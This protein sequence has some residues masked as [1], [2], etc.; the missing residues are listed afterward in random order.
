MGLIGFYGEPITIVTA[1]L[2]VVLV[3]VG[4]SA[5]L[6]VYYNLIRERS[7]EANFQK[8]VFH[9]LE[10]IISPLIVAGVTTFVGGI[11]L[12]VFKIKP[13]QNFGLFSGVGSLVCL[14]VSLL[15]IPVLLRL[16][17]TGSRG[18]AKNVLD[19]MEKP[20]KQAF[21]LGGLVKLARFSAEQPFFVLASLLL[22]LGYSAHYSYKMDIGYDNLSFLPK[23]DPVRSA[24]VRLR[25][26]MNGLRSF[27][28]TLDTKYS[29][30][31]LDLKFLE[32]VHSFQDRVK[33]VPDVSRTFS[34]VDLVVKVQE[35]LNPETQDLLPQD[36]DTVAQY[37]FLIGMGS[38]T[39]SYLS[40]DQRKLRVAVTMMTNDTRATEAAY[41]KVKAMAEEHFGEGVIVRA[42]GFPIMMVALMRYLVWGKIQNMLMA[43]LL[44]FLIVTLRYRSVV[45]GIITTLPL[46]IGVITNFG[47]MGYMGIRLDFVTAIITSFAMGIGIDFSI[48]FVAALRK[49]YKETGDLT[50]AV[51][52]AVS[53]P[54]TAI[55]YNAVICVA[56]F[57]VLG[58]SKFAPVNIFAVLMCFN[59]V[60]L[61]LAT[62]LVLPA[63]IQIFRPQFITGELGYQTELGRKFLMA[64]KVAMS[65]ALVAVLTV[66]IY[67]AEA[68]SAET[69]A[70]LLKKSI[71]ASHAK[72][73]ESVYIM[74]LIS[75]DGQESAPRKMNVW[76]QSEGENAK[77]MIKFVEPANIRGTGFL[78]VIEKDD[79]SQWLYLP[80][81]KKARRVSGGN[82]DEPFLGSDFTMGDISVDKK[83]GFEFKLSGEKACD[84]GQCYVLEGTPKDSDSL[85][86]KQ[87]RLIHKSHYLNV[88]SEFY[89]AAG[90][91]EKVM[92]L[93]NI[94][95][96]PDGRMAPGQVEMKN[97]LTG[98]RTVIEYAKRNT[99]KKPSA[100]VFTKR[101]L[102]K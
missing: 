37:L 85:Y 75:K 53:G 51:E 69:P 13:L 11:T 56:G 10:K 16:V 64:S 5:A 101:Y 60:V 82:S 2:P 47:L 102:E 63:V 76:F 39:A 44:I 54:G 61:M 95:K 7:H 79:A 66:G 17:G 45:R 52:H 74:K 86:S 99:S 70:S 27:D 62:F 88:R 42:G 50:A 20:E 25:E 59:M 33:E 12:L 96:G 72:H 24:A 67:V 98:S 18:A 41:E 71:K 4:C 29:N 77:L 14:V 100:R 55:V 94:K 21:R 38:K 19:S 89:N 30:G 9:G 36:S 6:H 84:G 31:A 26:R 1:I 73:E 46:P 58:L 97:M 81:I 15:M 83:G 87:I 28:L 3:V 90:Q 48:H 23:S 32:K 49:S 34:V 78:S 40:N 91:L 8:I 80:A 35:V 65:T 43:M 22:L 57:S 92:T 93:K 68:K